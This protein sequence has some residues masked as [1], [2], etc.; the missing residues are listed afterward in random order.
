M[1]AALLDTGVIVALLDKDDPHH[2]EAAELLSKSKGPFIVPSAVL[3]EVCY[4]AHKYLGPPVERAFVEGLVREEL[5]VDWTQAPDLRRAAEVMGDRPELGL[6]DS[7][8]VAAAERLKIRRI[9]TLDRRHF[10]SFR[11]RHC[12]AFELLP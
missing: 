1:T 4:L 10:A 12:P 2:V 3:A 7:L 8:V 6:V 9:A 5:P 11:P